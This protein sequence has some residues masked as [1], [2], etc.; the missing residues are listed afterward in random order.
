[1]A[2]L[3]PEQLDVTTGTGDNDT[4]STK[5]YVDDQAG[6]S[7][8]FKRTGTTIEP[9]NVGDDFD[10]GT[11]FIET[12]N[13]KLDTNTVSATSGNLN[14][15][16]N[17]G[18]VAINV[19]GAADDISLTP[20]SSTGLVNINNIGMAGNTISTTNTD[21]NLTLSP[22][23]DG[24][25]NAT[26]AVNITID[27]TA[28]SA[29]SNMAIWYHDITGTPAAGIGLNLKGYTH[30]LG[31]GFEQLFEI[32]ST[33]TDV[34]SGSEVSE[35]KFKTMSA[36]T[37]TSGVSI[38]NGDELSCG[39][40]LPVI[41]KNNNIEFDRDTNPSYIDQA[42]T[43]DIFFRFGAGATT[44]AEF[45]NDGVIKFPDVYNKTI[46]SAANVF[47]NSDGEILRATCG[48]YWK[49]NIRTL[50]MDTSDIYDMSIRTYEDKRTGVTRSS[51]IGNAASYTAFPE[52]VIKANIATA[53]DES[54]NPTAYD[55][56][57]YDSLDW[58]I[59]VTGLLNEMKKLRD[60][61]VALESA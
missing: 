17:A 28:V 26:K 9:Q 36:G 32:D 21:G 30:S 14:V 13:I 39:T 57:I 61:I 42:G 33:F 12:G 54:G 16:A 10:I 18:D 45:H 49:E 2:N 40:T 44:R 41:I 37:L 35:I 22:D 19:L 50:E 29:S 7:D 55:E 24:S 43:G 3:R 25:I 59:I 6:A 46:P 53:W 60:R 34:T 1:M 4:V 38:S 20:G 11:G 56:D 52:A 48:E 47:I 5:G 15:V 27:D 23:G 58:N 51:I 8:V 31:S